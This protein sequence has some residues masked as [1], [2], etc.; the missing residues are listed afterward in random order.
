MALL[1]F[2]IAYVGLTTLS[3]RLLGGAAGA[4]RQVRSVSDYHHAVLNV[5]AQDLFCT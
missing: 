1:Y 2:Q 5:L 4:F 3:W